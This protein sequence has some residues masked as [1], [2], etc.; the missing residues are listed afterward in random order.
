MLTAS[1]IV[2]TYVIII[3]SYLMINKTEQLIT[4]ATS[5]TSEY[6]FDTDYCPIQ[7]ITLAQNA[8]T[9]M[10]N[11]LNDCQTLALS[12]MNAMGTSFKLNMQCNAER[13]KCQTELVSAP[14]I[15]TKPILATTPG[16]VTIVAGIV[17]ASLHTNFCLHS[18]SSWKCL[19]PLPLEGLAW[20]SLYGTSASATP[21]LAD[22]YEEILAYSAYQETMENRDA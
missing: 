11:K 1:A 12:C 15:I 7:T 20:F 19:A 10:A 21:I 3:R 2:V 22:Y 13:I 6:M 14:E 8:L 9:D 17:I 16:I 18:E 5:T 4:M